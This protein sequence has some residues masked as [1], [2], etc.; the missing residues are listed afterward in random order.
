MVD[1]FLEHVCKNVLV[2]WS[3]V[4]GIEL[5]RCQSTSASLSSSSLRPQTM[6]LSTTLTLP[7]SEGT[8]GPLA[9][10]N[11]RCPGSS[12]KHGWLPPHK[13]WLH[14]CPGGWQRIGPLPFRWG[15][16]SLPLTRFRKPLSSSYGSQWNKSWTRGLRGGGAKW[17]KTVLLISYIFTAILSVM[18][19]VKTFNGSIFSHNFI[20]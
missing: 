15:R 5:R 18:K 16:P 11:Q 3:E 10:T 13:Q 17:A 8:C 7:L 19:H 4:S 6:S 14:S 1:A 12:Q 20:E 9:R 2:K